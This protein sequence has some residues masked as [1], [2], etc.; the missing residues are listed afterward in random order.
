MNQTLELSRLHELEKSFDPLKSHLSE[1]HSKLIASFEKGLATLKNKKKTTKQAYTHDVWHSFYQYWTHLI[2]SHQAL[3]AGRDAS[4]PDYQA[5]LNLPKS[6]QKILAHYH[7][8]LAK[9]LASPSHDHID[10]IRLILIQM[11][12]LL[13]Y[14]S[15]TEDQARRQAYEIETLKQALLTPSTDS[16][17]T[18]LISLIHNLIKLDPIHTEGLAYLERCSQII[19]KALDSNT[20]A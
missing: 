17:S 2:S 12:I 13:G 19:K 14:P 4:I 18:Q 11:D 7:R 6:M 10:Q 8:G 15:P 5:D 16:L 9:G 1:K 20:L 3:I